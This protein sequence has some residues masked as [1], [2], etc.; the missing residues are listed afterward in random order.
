MGGGEIP[1]PH[2]LK[3]LEKDDGLLEG[4]KKNL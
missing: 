3:N 2:D 4:C 1:Q